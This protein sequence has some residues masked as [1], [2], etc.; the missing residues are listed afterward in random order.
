MAP[1]RGD[2]AFTAMRLAQGMLVPVNGPG[3]NIS[4]FSGPRG[5]QLGSTSS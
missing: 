2:L 3:A 5:S 4:L 1:V